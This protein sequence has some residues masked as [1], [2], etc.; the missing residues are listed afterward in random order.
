M[1]MLDPAAASKD[2]AP[3][4]AARPTRLH[5]LITRCDPWFRVLGLGWLTP[6]SAGIGMAASSALVT[7][8][9]LRLFP[10]NRKRLQHGY[11]VFADSAISGDGVCNHWRAGV[12]RE[13]RAV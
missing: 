13:R 11:S 8:N 4:G 6:L 1:A 9:A 10:V 7:C 12:E 5:S 2:T 3:K